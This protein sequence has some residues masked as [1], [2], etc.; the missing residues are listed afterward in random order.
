MLSLHNTY[1]TQPTSSPPGAINLPFRSCQGGG[2]IRSKL[3]GEAAGIRSCPE[4]RRTYSIMDGARRRKDVSGV[5]YFAE[6]NIGDNHRRA[7]IFFCSFFTFHVDARN[8]R[9][10]ACVHSLE[11]CRVENGPTGLA[12]VAPRLCA[13]RSTSRLNI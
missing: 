8:M 11:G 12:R 10:S 6:P 7:F 4:Y 3:N 1:C 5:L 2:D 9:L 13:S